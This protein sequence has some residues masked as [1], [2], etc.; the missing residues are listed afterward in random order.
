MGTWIKPESIKSEFRQHFGIL[1]NEMGENR[2]LQEE[3]KQM[4]AKMLDLQRETQERLITIQKGIHAVLTQTY[5]LLE[6]PIP[7][8]FIVLP[9]VSSRKDIQNPFTDK[10][11]LY[12]L[13][14]CGEHTKT[15]HTNVPHYIHMAKHDGYDLDRPGEFF[16]K[17]G[18]Y[19]LGMLRMIELGV[20]VAGYIV[21]PLAHLKLAGGLS[22]MQKKLESL[23][24]TLESHFDS[25]IDH[26]EKLQKDNMITFVGHDQVDQVQA[27]EGAELRQ[28][29][30][31]L[32]KRDESRV[33][34]NLYRITTTTGHIKWVCCDHYRETYSEKALLAFS[35]N[36]RLNKGEYD[37][38]KGTVK[39][40]LKSSPS[41]RESTE[42]LS[43]LEIFRK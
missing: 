25:V 24:S 41:A 13:C 9:R 37:E 32:K 36:V 34:G 27:L 33:L 38:S 14:E 31:F 28:V 29:A 40:A 5:E 19:I 1:Q 35:E 43:R 39:I 22:V 10:F 7:R 11:R 26:L 4:L 20:S 17:Y 6:Y 8:L 23:G 30:T 18:S 16:E 21:P 2:D 12:F 3:M 42:C 15:P